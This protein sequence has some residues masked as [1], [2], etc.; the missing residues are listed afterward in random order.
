MFNGVTDAP[1]EFDVCANF[2]D[3][4]AYQIATAEYCRSHIGSDGG[5]DY[6]LLTFEM[7]TGVSKYLLLH[8]QGDFTGTAI[9]ANSFL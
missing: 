9:E 4:D 6:F 1:C 2:P 5:S 8:V 7:P 3:S